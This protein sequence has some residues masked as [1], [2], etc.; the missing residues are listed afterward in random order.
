ML[1][2]WTIWQLSKMEH[3]K[4]LKKAELCRSFRQC[5]STRKRPPRAIYVVL[6]N[7]GK[8]LVTC[9]VFLRKRYGVT[10]R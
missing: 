2:C 7:V 1:N 9:G 10:V 4:N 8:L 5:S 3:D 6:K